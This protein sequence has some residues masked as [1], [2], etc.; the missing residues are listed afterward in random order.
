MECVECKGRGFVLSTDEQNNSE[1]QRCDTCNVFSHDSTA[2][3][4]AYYLATKK[5]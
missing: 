5:E 3:D 2:Q 1:I 4:Y